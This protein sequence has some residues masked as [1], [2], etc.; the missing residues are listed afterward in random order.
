[1]SRADVEE[2]PPVGGAVGQPLAELTGRVVDGD[3]EVVG[4]RRHQV[5]GGQRA[6]GPA[7]DTATSLRAEPGPATAR[8]REGRT[9][10]V[11]GW[12]MR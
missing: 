9:S 8:S 12:S 3:G 2:V 5:D 10:W 1:M 4:P 6:A 7:A 11:S